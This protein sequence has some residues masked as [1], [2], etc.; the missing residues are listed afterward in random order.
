MKILVI[1]FSAI[2]DVLLTFPILQGLKNKYPEA[3]IHVLTKKEQAQLF[4]LLPFHVHQCVFSGNLIATARSIRRHKFD[5]VI[6][7]HNNLRTLL[8][9]VLSAKSHWQRVRK[10]NVL[11]WRITTFKKKNLIV[12]HIVTRYAKAAEVE[13]YLTPLALQLPKE[14]VPDLPENYIAWVVGAKFKT[15]QFPLEKIRETIAACD[16]PVVILGGKEEMPLG[17]TL[18][19]EFAHVIN[20]AGKTTIQEAAGILAWAKA[21]VTNDTGLMHLASFFNKRML[22]LWGNTVPEF[23]MGPYGVTKV[24]HFQ[25]PDLSCRPCSKI[26]YNTCPKG[27]FNCMQGQD[28]ALLAHRINALF[29]QETQ[30]SPE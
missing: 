30:E 18:E 14:N 6:D 23:G 4:D 12:P 9:Q 26:G 3:E 7:L 28:T 16:F 10:Y 13:E 22:V 27:H 21:V 17:E 11:K 8:L 5:R 2:G 25:V 15:K 19:L 20:I 29:H 1:R 24:S